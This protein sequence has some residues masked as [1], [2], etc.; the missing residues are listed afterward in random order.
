[1]FGQ[2]RRRFSKPPPTQRSNLSVNGFFLRDI[3]SQH[4]VNS[5]LN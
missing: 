2:L 3:D 4:S 5:H 1:M